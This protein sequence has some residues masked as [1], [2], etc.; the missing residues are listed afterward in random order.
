MLKSAELIDVLVEEQYSSCKHHAALDQCVIKHL[1][2]YII[3]QTWLDAAICLN[4][5][6]G[7]HDCIIQGTASLAMQQVGIKLTAIEY[8]L[9]CLQTL[10]HYAYTAYGT[11]SI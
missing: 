6:E 8:M 7:C 5:A 4:S 9:G 1:T 11:S 3:R 2:L 10:H